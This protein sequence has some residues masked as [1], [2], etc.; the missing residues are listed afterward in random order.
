MLGCGALGTVLSNLVVGNL[1]KLSGYNPKVIFQINTQA[2]LQVMW[3]VRDEE[4]LQK[5]L[6]DVINTQRENK[7][8]LPGVKIS[9][10]VVV[11]GDAASVAAAADV[12]LF[13]YATRHVTEILQTVKGHLKK[14]VL[15][16]SF[17]KVGIRNL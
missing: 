2:L 7:K 17:S 10:N 6:I 14:D 4:C 15:F 13:A 3:Y 12:I 9:D 16:I 1:S 5:R 8:Y 11:S